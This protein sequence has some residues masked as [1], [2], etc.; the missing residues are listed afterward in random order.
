MRRI[1]KMKWKPDEGRMKYNKRTH[2]LILKWM[3]EYRCKPM[4]YKILAA[5]FKMAWR[6]KT[7][8][9]IA[10]MN[11][12]DLSR[13]YRCRIWWEGI[14]TMSGRAAEGLVHAGKGPRTELEDIFV[15]IYSPGWR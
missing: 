14:K 10:G 12:L 6:E 4:H 8:P 15:L 7:F 1:F 2:A 11:H 3:T 13:N 9:K 5:V